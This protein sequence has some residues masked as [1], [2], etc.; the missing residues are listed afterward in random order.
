MLRLTPNLKLWL[1]IVG[2]VIGLVILL[3]ARDIQQGTGLIVATLAGGV[4]WLLKDLDHE[5]RSRGNICHAY[6]GVIETQFE[7]I[8]DSLSDTE[9]FRFLALA[10]AIANGTEP[11]AIGTRSR[12]PY[13]MLPD[14]RGQLH[15]LRPQTVR[16]LSKWRDL[17][18]ELLAVYD[19]LGT[20]ELSSF[21]NDRLK[22]HFEWVKQY[23]DQY[24]DVAYTAL[25]LG[26][27]TPGIATNTAMFVKEGAQQIA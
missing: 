24:R 1:A 15:V 12:D 14:L 13:A 26:E 11:A 3:V 23:R 6:A 7:E 25:L 18:D 4:G 21:P 19:R 10:P 27:E 2:F 9:L 16:M 22:K 5:S 8:K 20:R 17:N